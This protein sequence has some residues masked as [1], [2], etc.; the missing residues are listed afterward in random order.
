VCVMCAMTAA[1][2]AT[3]ARTWLQNAHLTWL[4]PQRLRRATVGLCGTAL[5][6]STVGLSGSTPPGRHSVRLNASHA[7]PIGPADRASDRR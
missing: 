7:A 1:A 4:T 3:G 6:V 2:G 5:V